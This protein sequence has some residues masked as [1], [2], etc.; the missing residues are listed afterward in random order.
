[1]SNSN[2]ATAKQPAATADPDAALVTGLKCGDEETFRLLLRRYQNPVYSYVRRLIDDP[3]EAEDVTQDIFVKVFQKI[4]G[5]REDS[6]FKTWLYRIAANEASNRR[7]WFS[8]NRWREVK[9]SVLGAEPNRVAERLADRSG[10]P[11]ERVDS[12]QQRAILDD[13]LR[14]L[15]P[16]YRQV[17]VLR[18]INGLTY[19]EIAAT[20]NLPLGTVKSRILRGRQAFRD[21]LTRSAPSMVPQ[22]MRWQTD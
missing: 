11:F 2:H 20:L 9:D 18:D 19:S 13:A 8:R 10:G 15:D 12:L 16:R 21:V 3:A 4:D 17:V 14:S 6:S 7:R 5:F 1:M 22:S